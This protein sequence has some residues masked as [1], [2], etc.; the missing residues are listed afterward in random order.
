[1]SKIKLCI[2]F[3]SNSTVIYRVGKGI[4]LSE[5][6]KILCENLNGDI[7]VKEFG[8]KAAMQND[9]QFIISPVVEGEIV[10]EKYAILLLRNFIRKVVS[11]K[12]KASIEAYFSVPCGISSESKQK[13]YS[14]AYTAGV[15]SITLV[16]TPIADLLGCGIGFDD[17]R[18][19]AIV[20][21]GS[22]CT[23]IAVLD[24]NG[25][26]DGITVNIGSVNIDYS[27]SM[28]IQS[29][30]GVKISLDSVIALKEQ[31]GSL[32]P[33][34]TK[35]LSFTGTELKTK[36]QKTIKITSI[37]IIE[38]LREHYSVVSDLVT[39]LIASQESVIINNIRSQGV[40]FCGN[41][42]KIECLKE[43]M[44][45]KLNMPIFVASGERSVFGLAKIAEK[46]VSLKNLF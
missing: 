44:Q 8:Q 23:D 7:I 24:K 1:M 37:D 34:G 3:G 16:A 39:S 9:N 26:V 29:K 18:N 30:F 14:I 43:F 17:F 42:S 5:P 21:I 31:I 28:Q 22:G 25:I 41:G 46:K 4:V 36:L 11:D 33:N 38:P 6:N 32:L 45:Q 20:D 35:N 13:Y 12:P 15:S 19:C 40:I 2:D 27:L 10:D